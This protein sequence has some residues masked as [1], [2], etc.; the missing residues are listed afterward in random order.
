MYPQKKQSSS[1]T[2]SMSEYD[3]DFY[4]EYDEEE[5]EVEEDDYDGYE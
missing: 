2:Y 5:D 1:N 3:S 4:D